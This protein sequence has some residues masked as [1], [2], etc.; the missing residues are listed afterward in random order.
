MFNNLTAN[1]IPVKKYRQ[2]KLTYDQAMDVLK[3]I[4]AGE[5]QIDIAAHY[6]VSS[7]TITFIKMSRTYQHV[8]RSKSAKI[9]R[10]RLDDA[11]KN[12][13]K[14]KLNCGHTVGDLALEH[15]VSHSMISSIKNAYK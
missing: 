14:I 5:K 2:S 10:V 13:I 12:A 8:N 9:T 3:R 15:G 7:S 11:T 1:T 4:E 6:G